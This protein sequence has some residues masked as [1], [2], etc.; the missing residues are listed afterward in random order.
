ME[1][2]KN[3]SNKLLK[4]LLYLFIA[5]VIMLISSESGYYEYRAY[6]KTRLTSEAIKQFEKDVNDNKNVSINDYLID[7][8]KDYSNLVTKTGNYLNKIIE[9]FM[10]DGIKKTLKV[11]SALFYE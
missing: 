7:E 10:N 4:V 8:Y 1:E 3:N 9:S 11:I 5:F 2:E 6:S